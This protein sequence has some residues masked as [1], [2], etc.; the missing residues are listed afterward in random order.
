MDLSRVKT[1]SLGKIMKAKI[2]LFSMFFVGTFLLS[3]VQLVAQSNLVL[4]KMPDAVSTT[5]RKSTVF[6]TEE[7]KGIVY[8]LNAEYQQAVKMRDDKTIDRI[9]SDDFVLVTGRGKVFSKKDLLNTAREGKII[10]ERQEDESQT[11]RVWG[12]MAVITAL[13]SAKGTNDGKPF[14]HKLWFSDVYRLTSDGWRHVF[15]QSSLPLAN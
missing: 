9:L 1:S 6:N 4:K 11:V 10:Y 12:D 8:K 13:L 14:E 15:A 3:S 2:G 5:G 7:I